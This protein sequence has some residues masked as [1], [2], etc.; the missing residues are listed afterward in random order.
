MIY[1]N[2]PFKDYLKMSGFN[3]STLKPYS[4]SPKWGFYKESQVFNQSGALK[5][6]HLVHSGALEGYEALRKSIEKD[7]IASGY[8][9]N[10]STGKPFGKG[11][12]KFTDWYAEQDQNK[13]VVFPD[14]IDQAKKIISSIRKH[15]ATMGVLRRCTE[16]ELVIT[17]KCQYTG[18]NCK[19]M[20]DACGPGVAFDLKTT[21]IDFTISKLEREMY[22][23]Q[24]HMQF[25]F[26][27]DGL[28]ANGLDPDE[29]YAGF[30]QNK[31]PYDVGCFEVNYTALEQGRTDYITAIA[32]YHKARNLK[33]NI[34]GNFPKITQIGIPYYAVIQDEE[35]FADEIEETFK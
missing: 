30:A 1:R 18:E 15:E 2:K 5:I 9:I 14:E 35:S 32:N 20:I 27:A 12:A 25:A 3:S 8:P 22:D 24:Y 16:R 10:S 33:E 13:D 26:Y 28:H 17:W 34:P 21:R 6:G 23:R 29:F 19:A 7:H 11:T 4:I 31:E